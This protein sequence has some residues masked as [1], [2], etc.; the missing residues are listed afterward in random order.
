MAPRV[1]RYGIIDSVVREHL[2]LAAL[3]LASEI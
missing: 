1:L 2:C 3:T